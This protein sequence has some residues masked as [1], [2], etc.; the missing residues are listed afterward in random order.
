M[1]MLTLETT[2]KDLFGSLD[3]WDEEE[4]VL[5]D[6]FVQTKVFKKMKGKEKFFILVGEKGTGKS[7]IMKMCMIEDRAGEKVVVNIQRP[8][9]DEKLDINSK[10][11][12]WK[13][14]LSEKILLTLHKEYQDGTKRKLITIIEEGI[15][16]YVKSK[17][18][19]DYKKIKME[20]LDNI[21][22][23]EIIVYIDD[24]DSG[25]R[26]MNLQNESIIALFT[27]IRE[28]IR[29]NSNLKFRVTLRTDVYD[30]VRCVDESSDKIQDARI[31]LSITNHQI[32]AMLTKRV[33]KYLTGGEE[34]DYQTLEQDK[35]IE[36]MQEV[37]SPRFNGKGRWKDKPV[38]HILMA[39]TRRRPRDLFVLC[40]LAWNHAIDNGRIR[41]ESEDLQSVFNEYSNER[42]NDAIAEYHHEFRGEDDL[43]EL[44]LALK[45]SAKQKKNNGKLH[46]YTK[47]SLLNKIST[48]TNRK[49]F[50]WSND[51]IATDVELMKFLYKANIIVGRVDDD[52]MIKRVY[53]MEKPNL[54][55][56]LGNSKYLLE[57]HPAY[58]WAI[59]V[60]NDGVLQEIDS[61]KD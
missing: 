61:E 52:N 25:Y 54:I 46:L 22:D 1:G 48:I 20:I 18:H 9:V 30:N 57:V 55:S 49:K 32:L 60:L 5:K 13:D 37:F 44:V 38:H 7:A 58:R 59:D 11:N 51:R 39:L 10:V 43:K 19:I 50:F 29:E 12:K 42:L 14:Y 40:G 47:D 8:Q 3:A 26:G 34:L 21:H 17:Y 2:R 41:I 15:N 31:D 56:T 16:D 6:Y 4:G 45:P 28:M 27:A 24:L 36:K 33:M 23:S 53:Y 35:M